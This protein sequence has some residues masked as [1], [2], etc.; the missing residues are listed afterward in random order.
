MKRRELIR[1]LEQYGCF[2]VREGQSHSIYENCA[3]RNRASVPR[4]REIPGPLVRVIC[5]QLAIP[6][7]S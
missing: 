2:L 4:H 1:D 5:R 6:V 3:N 7:P